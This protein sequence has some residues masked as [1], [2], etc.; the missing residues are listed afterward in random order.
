MVNMGHGR[1]RRS[2]TEAQCKTLE[3]RISAAELMG[4]DFLVNMLKQNY[5]SNCKEVSHLSFR[6]FCDNI[7]P[8]IS[9]LISREICKFIESYIVN[10]NDTKK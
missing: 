10:G 3:E 2:N 7:E 4:D 5:D 8:M 6:L 9:S 1:R